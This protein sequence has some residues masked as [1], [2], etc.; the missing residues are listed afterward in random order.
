MGSSGN[1]VVDYSDFSTDSVSAH[2]APGPSNGGHGNSDMLGNGPS[3]SSSAAAAARTPLQFEIW[4]VRIPLL[5]LHGVQ[6]KKLRGNSWLYKSL[7]SK[8]LAEL[9][10]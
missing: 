6:F 1:I 2:G 7:A 5:S 10:L 4:I 3:P 9:R 8:I